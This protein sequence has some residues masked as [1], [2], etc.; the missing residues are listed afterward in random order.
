MER[1]KK[2]C[3]LL[4]IG[5]AAAYKGT[6]EETESQIEAAIT[7]KEE[8][9]GWWNNVYGKCAISCLS[10]LTDQVASWVRENIDG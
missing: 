9:C 6:L 7:C 3:P 2:M 1:G 10:D 8:E 5:A 4:L